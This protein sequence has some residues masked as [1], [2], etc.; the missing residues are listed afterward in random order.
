MSDTMA[1]RL[2]DLKRLISV[3]VVFFGVVA[4]LVGYFL[5]F[6]WTKGNFREVVAQKVYRSA[7]PMLL[8]CRRG[9]DRAGTA[10]AAGGHGDWQ[11]GL[12]YGEVA[13]LRAAGT[14]ESAAALTF[15]WLST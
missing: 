11:G 12:R 5:V 6:Y 10:S 3:L 1:I 4:V 13:G 15:D 9:I 8:R 7:Q 14:M 2:R